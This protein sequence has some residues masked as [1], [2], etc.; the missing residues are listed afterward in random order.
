MSS[1]DN[2]RISGSIH[3]GWTWPLIRVQ[4]GIIVRGA[5]GG[6]RSRSASVG[7][8]DGDDFART[9]NCTS[10]GLQQGH[11]EIDT[12]EGVVHAGAAK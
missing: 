9:D 7:T 6:Q 8:G 2:V 11:C 12:T 1:L 3:G 5:V 10:W 4:L